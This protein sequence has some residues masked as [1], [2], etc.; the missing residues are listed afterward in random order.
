[1]RSIMIAA[2]SVTL[3]KVGC[4]PLPFVLE[5]SSGWSP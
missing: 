3:S 5:F 1:M 4:L 2:L